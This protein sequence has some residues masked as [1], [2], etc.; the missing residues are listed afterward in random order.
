MRLLATVTKEEGQFV[1]QCLDVDVASEG[2]TVEA[3]LI[4]L[5]EAVE[6]FLEENPTAKTLSPIVATIDVKVA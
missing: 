2:L 6:L 3:A 5:Q 1:A 4:N